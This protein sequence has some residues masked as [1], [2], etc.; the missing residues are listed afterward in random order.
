MIDRKKKDNFPA[1]GEYDIQNLTN[2]N[3]NIPA[4]AVFGREHR[5]DRLND[6]LRETAYKPAPGAFNHSAFH[7]VKK[8]APA[9]SF[10]RAV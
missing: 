7:T 8:T 2:I 5:K 6:H 9:C 10:G 3:H 4:K 1:A